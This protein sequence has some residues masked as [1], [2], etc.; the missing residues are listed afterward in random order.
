[1][2]STGRTNDTYILWGGSPSLYTGKV[3]SYLIK[4]SS[5]K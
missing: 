3:R 2:T 5:P 4:G 1:M